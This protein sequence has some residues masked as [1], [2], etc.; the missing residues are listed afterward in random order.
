MVYNALDIYVFQYEGSYV[1]FAAMSVSVCKM[2]SALGGIM[3]IHRPLH[4]CEEFD[5]IANYTRRNNK[6]FFS[7]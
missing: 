3:Y 6:V 4:S 2:S 5:A 7:C 1:D